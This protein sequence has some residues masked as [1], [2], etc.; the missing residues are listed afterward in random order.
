MHKTIYLDI[1]KPFFTNALLE[2][3]EINFDWR[4]TYW[5]AFFNLNTPYSLFL[6]N[7]V[8]V[9]SKGVFRVQMPTQPCRRLLLS[10]HSH[11]P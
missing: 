11:R 7:I 4:D 9:Q 6:T 8:R 3:Y 10:H 5:G 1:D 2:R